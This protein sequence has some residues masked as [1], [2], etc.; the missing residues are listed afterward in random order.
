MSSSI[1]IVMPV[2]NEAG[3]IEK[4]LKSLSG[5]P[6]I[7]EIIVVDGGSTDDTVR[8]A[9]VYAKVIHAK[10]RRA[11]QMN[12][13]AKAATGDIIIFLHADCILA[14]NGFE[15]LSK[16]IVNTNVVGGGFQLAFDDNS[17]LYKLIAFG[18]N[19][20]AKIFKLFFGDQGIF[21]RREVFLEVEGFPEVP[22][23]EEWGLCQRLRNKGKLIM[24]P[25]PII[26]SSRRFRKYGVWKTLF[27]MHKLKLLYLLGV[28]PDKLKQ[29][30]TNN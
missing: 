12:A 16:T 28:S 14:S 3:I 18:S 24:L 17:L 26:T 10:K 25:I 9:S 4:T 29:Q 5:I 20:R 19:Q 11:Q 6:G 23:M 21:V 27:L 22:I 30:Y 8:I 13:G 2:F 15:Y 7:E 1:S